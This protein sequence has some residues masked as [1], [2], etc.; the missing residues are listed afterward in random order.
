MRQLAALP[1]LAL[2]LVFL[3]AVPAAADDGV[4]EVAFAN[5]GAPAAQAP[6]RR[7]LALLHNFE[8]ADAAAEFKKAQAIDPGFAMA[9]WGEA[10]TYNHPVWMQQDA[11]AARA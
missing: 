3:M 7:G 2:S 1:L 11:G 10:M 8:Y 9:Y 5:S 4:G 6:F